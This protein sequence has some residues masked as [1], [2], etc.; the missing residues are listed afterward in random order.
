[1]NKCDICL[2]NCSDV[3][4]HV[5]GY[6]VMRCRQCGLI[7][8]NVTESDIVH[9]YEIDYYK[10]IYPDYESDSNIHA[11]NNIKLLHHIERYFSPGTLI[12]IGSAFGFFLDAAAKN[13]WK[14][15][16]FEKS[17]YAS[18]I[19]RTK[20]HQ[21]VRT[22]DFLDADIQCKVDLICMFDTIEHLLKP[23]LYIEKISKTLTKGGGLII[24]TGD[25]SSML[26]RIC[27]K[28]WRM[29]L[30]PLHVY[31]YSRKTIT[32]LLERFGFEILS[33]T[34]ESKDQ[35]LNSILKHLFRIDKNAIPAIPIKVNVGDIM[36]IIARKI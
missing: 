8:S 28:N 32:R 19:A 26:A 11:R 3:I 13:K 29:V 4:W 9:A 34:T 23:S 6:D 31:Y 35:N 12:E 36:L 21:D 10:K 15:F 25:I 1:M 24:T 27:G 20:Y 22:A 14:V 2:E 7:F 30:P 18:M 33:I 16:G 5:N 17:E